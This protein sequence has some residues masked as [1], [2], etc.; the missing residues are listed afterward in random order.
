MPADEL[1]NM[2]ALNKEAFRLRDL[3]AAERS[4]TLESWSAAPETP[5]PVLD[6]QVKAAVG[7]PS[8]GPVG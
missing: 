3:A 2:K 5:H 7:A 6:A 4:T 8:R 1:A